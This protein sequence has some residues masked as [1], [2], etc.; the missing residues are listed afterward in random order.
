MQLISTLLPVLLLRADFMAKLTKAQ[1]RRRMVECQNK[2]LKAMDSG[3]F[4]SSQLDD[5]WKMYKKFQFLE[6]K[7]K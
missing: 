5:L 6:S 7:L 3:H 1:T 2:I 4:T